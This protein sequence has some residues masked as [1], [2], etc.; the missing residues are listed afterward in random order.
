MNYIYGEEAEVGLAELI[1]LV[2]LIRLLVVTDEVILENSFNPFT[3]I[4]NGL[5]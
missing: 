3:I 1:G 4:N 2:G 5:I